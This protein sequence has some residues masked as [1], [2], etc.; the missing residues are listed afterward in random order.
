[1]LTPAHVLFMTN[2]GDLVIAKRDAAKY[3]LEGR[4]DLAENETWAVP[5]FV[6]GGLVIRDAQGL[7]MLSWGS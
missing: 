7:V 5:A 6:P 2:A 3:A 1:L 4:I